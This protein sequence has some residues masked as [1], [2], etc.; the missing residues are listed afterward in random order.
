M[1]IKDKTAI[2]T[3]ATGKLAS[4]IVLSFAM[5]GINCVCI[6]NK[7]ASQAKK[8]QTA[9]KKLKV[10]SL[11]LQT[12]LMNSKNI[13]TIFKDI[14]KFTS[15]QILIN[16]A[17]VFEKKL[18]LDI[19]FQYVRQMLDVNF[20]AAMIL[21]Q[22]FVELARRKIKTKQKPIGKII[23][24]TDIVAQIPPAGFSVYAASKAAVIAATK[25]LAKEL[26]PDFTVNAV[27][28]GVINWQR[29]TSADLKKRMLARIPAGRTGSPQEVA[30]AVK[31]LVEND[32]VTGQV[33]NIDGGRT[34]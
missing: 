26:T 34:I 31:F 24:I 3:G 15:P 1:D 20:T 17:A 14:E 25:S 21:S 4:Q 6:Y 33:I 12:D 19:D 18:L 8:L 7:N 16:A 27:S 28:P 29:G 9:L 23:N 30:Y 2:I 13:E 5:A 10:K 11:F 32:Y 22:K